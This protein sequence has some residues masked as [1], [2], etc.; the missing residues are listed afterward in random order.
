MVSEEN[1]A[2]F[3]RIVDDVF[4]QGKVDLIGELIDPNW[5]DH[6]PVPGHESEGTKRVVTKFRDAFPDL[7]LNI[8]L[9]MADRDLVCGRLTTTGTH[10]GEFMGIPPTNKRFTMTEVHIVRFADGKAV[11]H[12]GNSDQLGKMRQLGVIPEVG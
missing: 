11:E 8:D 6:D 3:R 1:K 12:W 7:T 2:R 9:L 10:K 5:I 4:S